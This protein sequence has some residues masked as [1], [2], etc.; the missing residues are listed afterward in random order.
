[1]LPWV[2]K[3][4]KLRLIFDVRLANML[5]RAPPKTALS[6][7]SAIAGLRIRLD[8]RA[9]LSPISGIVVAADL[10]DGFYQF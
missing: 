1:M 6:T 7:A 9:S 5:V 8:S 4:N 10:V 3:H 2:E